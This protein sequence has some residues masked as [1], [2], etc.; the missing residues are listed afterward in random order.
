[1]PSFVLLTK[2]DNLCELVE[3]DIRNTYSSEK[4]KQAVDIAVELY[5]VP[6]RAWYIH[7]YLYESFISKVEYGTHG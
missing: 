3:K 4:M 5:N 7:F 2:I 1:V 6:V